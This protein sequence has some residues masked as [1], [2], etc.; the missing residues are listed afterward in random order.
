MAQDSDSIPIR[1]KDADAALVGNPSRG[2]GE[3]NRMAEEWQLRSVRVPKGT[4][5]ANSKGTPGAQRDLLYTNGTNALVGPAESVPVDKEEGSSPDYEYAQSDEDGPGL[6]A[7]I[8]GLALIGLTIGTIAM[9]GA[10][11]DKNSRLRELESSLAEARRAEGQA[12]VAI[13]RVSAPAG[14]Y[15]ADSGRQRWW[16]GQQWTEHFQSD[17]RRAPAPAGWYDDG[18]GNLRWWDGHEW[19]AHFQTTQ[20]QVAPRSPGAPDTAPVTPSTD[21]EAGFGMPQIS[22]SSA[23][24][25]ERVRAMLLARAFSEEQW[26]LLSNA[27]IDDADGALLDWQSELNKLTPQQFSDRINY[28]LERNPALRSS[29]QD[30]ALAGWYY[31]GSGQQQWWDGQQ[32]TERFQAE[33]VKILADSRAITPAGWYDDGSGQQRWWDGQ[34]WT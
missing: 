13:S 27:R 22:M 15:D 16:D 7:A 5:L 29:E 18:S 4:H 1:A 20:G 17:P 14:W 32:W 33:E 12:A 8:A 10:S 23:E 6:G 3:R 19:T 34:Q 9:V 21:V 26:R 30:P 28:M 31:D 25:Q 24:W 11:R 2:I